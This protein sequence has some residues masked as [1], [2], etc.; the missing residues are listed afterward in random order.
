MVANDQRYREFFDKLDE[1]N[2]EHLDD[3]KNATMSVDGVDWEDLSTQLY[4]MLVLA[5]PEDSAGETI[6]RNVLH[7]EG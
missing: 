1:K 3:A 7:S 5:M 2:L 4:Y 6:M